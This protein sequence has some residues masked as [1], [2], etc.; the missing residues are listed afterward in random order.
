[1]SPINWYNPLEGHFVP[2]CPYLKDTCPLTQQFCFQKFIHIRLQKKNM[3]KDTAYSI[4]RQNKHETKAL[5]K[6]LQLY[7]P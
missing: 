7:Y 1:M 3:Y 4:T 2:I 5:E 6:E